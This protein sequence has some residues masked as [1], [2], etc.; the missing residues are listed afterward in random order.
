MG[1]CWILIHI[2]T[3]VFIIYAIKYPYDGKMIFDYNIM[4][5][6]LK[7]NRHAI[8][9]LKKIQAIV[10]EWLSSIFPNLLHFSKIMYYCLMSNDTEI[11]NWNKYNWLIIAILS[12]F[13]SWF[14]HVWHHKLYSA[15]HDT[16]RIKNWNLFKTIQFWLFI[17]RFAMIMMIAYNMNNI[18]LKISLGVY[19][20]MLIGSYVIV[21]Y[22]K[23]KWPFVPVG[24][25]HSAFDLDTDIPK[26]SKTSKRQ[27]SPPP[28]P[29]DFNLEE[30]GMSIVSENI[31][32]K[33]SQADPL[34]SIVEGV[35]RIIV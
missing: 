35:G 19:L 28:P 11:C 20:S 14:F 6:L 24:T 1:A 16:S 34:Q 29:V 8:K 23:G 5:N 2:M 15:F 10:Q 13:T 9:D 22:D 3:S 4:T 21:R 31:T 17:I 30:D 12:N 33:Q 18:G 26:S 25:S 27:S 32:R 7:E